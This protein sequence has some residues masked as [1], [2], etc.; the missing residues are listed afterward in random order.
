MKTKNRLHLKNNKIKKRTVFLF[1]LVSTLLWVTIT[2]NIITTTQIE[3]NN[4]KIPDSFVGYKIA[5]ISDLHNKDWGD[6][7]IKPLKK[8]SPDIIVITGDL[9]DS[10][11]MDLEVAMDFIRN[12]KSIAPI[13]Y[14]SGNHEAWSGKYEW[15]KKELL[16]EDVIIMDDSKFLLKKNNEEILLLGLK[17][18]DFSKSKQASYEISSMIAETIEPMMNNYEGYVVL[19]SH[20]PEHFETY[21][22]LGVDLAF[23]G[24]AHGGQV[25]LPFIGGLIAPN[26]GLFPKFTAG[27]YHKDQ[28]DMI[29]S[30]GLGNSIIPIRVNNTP[31]LV[32]V[33]L[34][35]K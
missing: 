25:R 19:L 9:I 12:A 16:K 24:H 4:S 28:M 21:T 32:I 26:Q 1:L 2:N 30:R 17:D 6:T 14:V 15:L 33:E 27:V 35:N 18:P 20:R 7:L 13:Y 3:I 31:E 8:S 29:V 34:N 11:H 10:S 5:H 22:L 23:T